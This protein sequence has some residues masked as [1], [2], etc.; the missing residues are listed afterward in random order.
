MKNIYF[1]GK[2]TA[3][4]LSPREK[5]LNILG[6]G[7][8]IST[9]PE[10]IIAQAIVVKTFDELE[11]RKSEVAGKILVYNQE[12][13]DY[14]KT[15]IYRN[16]GPVEA[17]KLG[18]VACLVRSV[19]TFSINTPHTG[20]VRYKPG[21]KDIPVASVTQEDAEFLYRLDKAKKNITIHFTMEAQLKND[22]ISRN[23]W[24]DLTG[25]EKPKNVVITSCHVD[26]W[27]VG[28]GA[29]DDGGGCIVSLETL[30][31]LNHLGLKPRR[32]MRNIW[33][34]S[35]EVS[36]IGSEAYVKKHDSE[37]SN[38][39]MVTELDHGVFQPTGF[40]YAG[41]DKGACIVK[42]VLNLLKGKLPNATALDHLEATTADT[43]PFMPYGVPSLLLNSDLHKYMYYHHTE[44]DN[45]N[46]YTPEDLDACLAAWTVA[47]YVIAD[48]SVD[49]PRK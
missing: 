27:D 30:N 13:I 21:V 32:T 48:L 26:S 25:K 33:F 47:T 23:I 3:K 31:L 43:G 37:M 4:L 14:P 18:A 5:T 28:D 45:L 11:A 20:Q 29:M 9:P 8:S 17:S 16:K 41:S 49:I 44:G 19:A 36:I 22:V 15:I 2:E 38:I 42:E 12:W 1:R 6:L 10:G 40:E 24:G 39:D 35:E 46:V 7:L 34:T